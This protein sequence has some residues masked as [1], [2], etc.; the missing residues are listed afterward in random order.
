MKPIHRWM[1]WGILVTLLLSMDI[2]QA[3][4]RRKA[5]RKASAHVS[6]VQAPALEVI[7]R[8]VRVNDINLGPQLV[9]TRNGELVQKDVWVRERVEQIK[10]YEAYYVKNRV[11]KPVLVMQ[12]VVEKRVV[13]RKVLKGRAGESAGGY[14][15]TPRV[16]E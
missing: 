9:K 4:P 8:D 2:A 12:P 15:E 11:T 7:S 6:R 5:R 13:R 16:L 3:R 10:S 1:I 14:E